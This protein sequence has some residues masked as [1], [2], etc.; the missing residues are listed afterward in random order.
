MK[1]IPSGIKSRLVAKGCSKKFGVNYGETFS[2]VCRY[3]NI[4]L[5][6]AMLVELKMYL[7]QMDVCTAYLKSPLSPL[8]HPTIFDDDECKDSVLRLNKAIYRL[9]QA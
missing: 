1:G 2:P 6:L 7:Q 3:E 8:K 5:V 4:R 9:K